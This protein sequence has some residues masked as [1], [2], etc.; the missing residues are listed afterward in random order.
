MTSKFNW[1]L[2]YIIFEG[3]GIEF[4]K[5][6]SDAIENEITIW[7]SVI[8][9]EY[10][11][12]AKAHYRDLKAVKKLAKKNKLNLKKIKS[13]GLVPKLAGIS[14]IMSIILGLILAFLIV[15]GL[16]QFVW[17]IEVMG[18]EN[19][20]YS[21]IL[22]VAEECGIKIGAYGKNLELRDIEQVI[23]SKVD[24]ISW[25]G[26]SRKGSTVYIDLRERVVPQTPT[27]NDEPCNIVALHDG[28]ITETKVYK[29]KLLVEQNHTVKKGDIIV[30][31]AYSPNG[32]NTDM[33]YTH[34]TAD[35]IAECPMK[36]VFYLPEHSTEKQR[37]NEI[38][39]RKFLN[40][41]NIE[42]PLF[43]ATKL[44]DEFI[45]ESET[46]PITVFSYELPIKFTKKTYTKLTEVEIDNSS[47]IDE[48][49][50][51]LINN[52]ESEILKS[53]EILSKEEN[54]FNN[55]GIYT[56]ETNYVLKMN[57]AKEEIIFVK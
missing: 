7:D 53:V 43:V 1:L 23:L 35:I 20:D 31:G 29:G 4:N 28:L 41:Y 11:F 26:I 57:I 19:Y 34:A 18:E 8:F 52:Y 10:K 40:I 21:N 51:E 32:E 3:E 16:S 9:D 48:R 55:N 46:E 2:G 25:I 50:N 49:M 56:C 15:S 14:G 30:S 22:K 24:D 12:S 39:E 6:L 27:Y 13:K 42:I 45:C 33:I 17:K 38:F 36:K 47:N 54:R 37:T 44:K 5:F